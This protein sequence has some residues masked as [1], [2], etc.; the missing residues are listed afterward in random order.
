MKHVSYDPKMLTVKGGPRMVPGGGERFLGPQG[1][2]VR[3]SDDQ[4]R[5]KDGK[6]ASGGGAL[7]NSDKSAWTK[8]SLITVYHGKALNA[9][10][11][12]MHPD[13]FYVTADKSMAEKYF[14]DVYTVDVPAKELLPD[15]EQE[16]QADKSLS[17]LDSL[18]MGSAV[19]PD[20]Y[21][22]KL[23]KEGTKSKTYNSGRLGR[24]TIP[25]DERSLEQRYSEDQPRDDHGRFASGGGESTQEVPEE[26]KLVGELEAKMRELGNEAA[27]LETSGNPAAHFSRLA[28]IATQHHTLYQRVKEL[29]ESR[30]YKEWQAQQELQHTAEHH[31]AVEKEV[32]RV[33]KEQN[34]ERV[35]VLSKADSAYPN[36]FVVGGTQFSAGGYADLTNGM[37]T[38]VSNGVSVDYVPQIM[39]HE[40][41][42]ERFQAALNAYN[43]EH[44]T[45]MKIPGDD[46]FGRPGEP[47]TG[48]LMASGAVRP[49]YESRYPVTTLLQKS[50]EQD[51]FKLYDSD[52]CTPYSEAYWKHYNENGRRSE[53]GTRAMHE[54]LAEM[55]RVKV[56]TG[57]FPE[58]SNTGWR[59]LYRAVDKVAKSGNAIWPNG[60]SPKHYET[61]K[62]D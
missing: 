31:A 9:G 60:L 37:I 25:D 28:D 17:G 59:D 4:P 16:G 39:A 29:K 40:I 7:T 24:V 55:A 35:M 15:P 62:G 8:D 21:Y 12:K 57:K 44:L 46:L 41:E 22:E 42:H 43:Y 11:G 10:T 53:D 13:G 51:R 33:A 19:A 30:P 56:T 48:V 38:I 50:L 34:Y 5:D 52:G 49:E 2:E 3:Y 61:G 20:K 6:F 27:A 45:L 23:V 47:G 32:A 14:G 58:K 54:T 18:K 1:E 36:G 26:V